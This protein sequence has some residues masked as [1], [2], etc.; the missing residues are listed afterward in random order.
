M[1]DSQRTEEQIRRHFE[2]ER[3]LADRLRRSSR[4][5]RIALYP[6]LYDELFERIP[7][8]PRLT[9]QE[10]PETIAQAVANRMRLLD[11]QLEGIDTFLEIAPGDCR[12]AF[13][14]CKHVPNVIGADISDQIRFV[15]EPPSNF[16]H[17]VYDGFDLPL[18][19]DSVDMVFSYQFLEHIHPDDVD[20]HFGTVAKVLRPSGRYIFDTPHRYSG[21]YDVSRHFSDTALGFHL[22]EW[23]F[24]EMIAILRKHGFQSWQCYRKGRPRDSGLVTFAT[25]LGEALLAPFPRKLQRKLSARLYRSV[26]M[27]ATR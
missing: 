4:E 7:D 13:E 9:K 3:E 21:P 2:V 8:H 15:T 5:E 17:V 23:T 14:V 6:K 24:R 22:H 27:V 11:G 25:T 1:N 19:E 20:H 16:Q 18:N 10:T 26:A 12:L